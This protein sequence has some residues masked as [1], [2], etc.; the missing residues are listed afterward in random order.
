MNMFSPIKKMNINKPNF[1]EISMNTIDVQ[2]LIDLIQ[3]VQ[4]S[5]QIQTDDPNYDIGYHNGRFEVVYRL[6]NILRSHGVWEDED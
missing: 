3:D 2:D 5:D 6:E 4:F 1:T